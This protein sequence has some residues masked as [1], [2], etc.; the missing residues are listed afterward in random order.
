M[1]EKTLIFECLHWLHKEDLVMDN[2]RSFLPVSGDESFAA[3]KEAI[4]VGI[5]KTI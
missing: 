1:A 3:L 2:C 5:F 4:S